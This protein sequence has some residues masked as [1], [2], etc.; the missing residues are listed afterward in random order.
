MSN[1]GQVKYEAMS[2][3]LGEQAKDIILGLL[4]ALTVK[5]RRGQEGGLGETEAMTLLGGTLMLVQ[6]KVS[7]AR[8]C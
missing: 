5:Q 2:E 6:F 3:K 8:H 4:G 1:M 7:A